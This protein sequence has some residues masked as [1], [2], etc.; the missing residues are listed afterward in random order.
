MQS[1]ASR[2]T[3]EGERHKQEILNRTDAE[4]Q[5]L[6]GEGSEEASAIK[7]KVDA[8]IID[9]YAKA[10][11]RTGEFYNFIRTLE[12]YEASFGGETRLILSTDSPFL[13][14]LRTNV[15]EPV[16]PKK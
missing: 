11:T 10:I 16:V 13:S 8:E 14:L 12:A 4:V 5:K 1:I 3:N 9:V 2:Y 7:G 15:L 6:L